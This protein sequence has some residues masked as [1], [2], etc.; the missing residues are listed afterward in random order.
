MC[1]RPLPKKFW[2]PP[3]IDSKTAVE[4]LDAQ[5]E[6]G[7][8][9]MPS[10]TGETLL[11]P[12]K[13]RTH[14]TSLDN[15]SR[16]TV[17]RGAIGLA[18]SATTPLWAQG[19]KEAQPSDP[20]IVAQVVDNSIDQVDVSR[21]FLIGSRA[22]WRE[23]NLK[24]GVKGRQVQHMTLD[25]DGTA[26]SLQLAVSTI[27]NTANCVALSGTA[28]DRAAVQLV[29]LMQKER[30]EIAHVAPWLQS[31]HLAQDDVTFPIFA[32][33][34]EQ[35]AQALKSFAIM[36]VPE[37][38]VVY[39][40]PHEHEQYQRD[41]EQAGT[42][43]GI[44]LKSI[45]LSLNLTALGPRLPPGTPHL[46]LF[47]GGTP[48]LVQFLGGSDL[49]AK[50][51]SVMAFANVNL[52]TMMQMG[53]TQRTPVMATQVVPMVNSQMAIV[54]SYREALLRF[55]D[56]PPTPQSLAGYIS[57]Q[58]TAQILNRIDGAPTRQTALATFRKRA[59]SDLGGFQ[60]SFQDRRRTSNYVTQSMITPDG[61]LI[62]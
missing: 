8:S 6:Y 22:A 20:L 43:L 50:R 41:V 36:G 18:A 17:L 25:V 56:E 60:V 49:Q 15:K 39:A 47:V 61:R 31:S 28:G 51:H 58:Y 44:R 54:R 35:I 10:A 2:F 23:I 16:R 59:S 9:P 14:M 37:I 12:T 27:K 1:V 26:A 33:R 48:E 38:G 32:S 19:R 45:K 53:T 5:V 13:K 52:N 4:G 11:T 55:F 42:S 34:Q 40:S 29:T 21:D 3:F 30:L 62:G 24:G 7:E 46:L 57:A